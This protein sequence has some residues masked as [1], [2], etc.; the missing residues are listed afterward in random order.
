M[1]ETASD[2]IARIMKAQKRLYHVFA[3]DRS[4]PLL[5]ANLTMSQLK[6]AAG[7]ARCAPGRPGRT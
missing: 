2:T 3:F 1:S 4:D 6:V 5:A 7:P